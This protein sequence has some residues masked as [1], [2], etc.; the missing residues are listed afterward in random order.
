M[1]RR[2]FVESVMALPLTGMAANAPDG[3]VEYTTFQGKRVKLRPWVGKHVAFLT[4]SEGVDEK[5]MGGLCGVFDKVRDFYREATGRDPQQLKH[6]DGKITVA[7]VD[8]TCGAAC[9]YLGATG[10]EL[11]P[12]VFTELCGG[13]QKGELVDQAL[14]Y[15]FGR[16]FWFY[17]PQLAYRKPVSDRSV[18]T[19]YAVFMRL[20]ALDAAGAKLGPFRDKTGAEFRGVMEG[21][22]DLYEADAKFRWENTLKVDAAPENALGL[23]GTDLFASFC[24]RLARDH[25]GQKWV[26]AVWQAAGKLP[27]AKTTEE[28]VDHF[29]VAAS[30]AAKTDLGEL[31]AGRWRWPVSA[32]GRKAAEAAAKDGVKGAKAE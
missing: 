1:K 9:G 32:A 29:V 3:L 16:N 27:E 30:A 14:P 15:E 23:N 22:V 18:V 10:I 8:E 20:M 5:V 12:G 24:L 28:A 11:T 4:K 21:L 19:G 6:L 25:G 17:S 2:R 31:F 13:W 26:K 7:E